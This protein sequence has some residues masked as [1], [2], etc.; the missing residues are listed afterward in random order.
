MA[1]TR[2]RPRDARGASAAPSGSTL[3]SARKPAPA[4]TSD[5]LLQAEDDGHGLVEDQELG[6]G[7]VA[8]E[9]QL[10]H[11]AQL[12]ERLVDVAHAQ[13]L[14]G[15]VRHPPLLLPLRLLLGRQ[16]LVVVIAADT[17][18]DAAFSNGGAERDGF[19]IPSDFFPSCRGAFPSQALVP[20]GVFS[21]PGLGTA[22]GGYDSPCVR[23]SESH[24]YKTQA[25][26]ESFRLG[27]QVHRMDRRQPKR[28]NTALVHKA[29][30][31]K[32][33]HGQLRLKLHFRTAIQKGLE[34]ETVFSFLFF[35]LTFIM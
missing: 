32:A 11:A 33:V 4:L 35:F 34:T 18:E 12:L 24:R 9:V 25:Q 3:A 1:D 7:L 21:L 28:E 16:V 15:V 5:L 22:L 30:C 17:G 29:M 6:L 19:S 20:G 10:H 31:G 8:L 13:A 23:H 27:P 26:Q 2:E 14:A